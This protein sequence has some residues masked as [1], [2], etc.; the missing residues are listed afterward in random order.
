MSTLSRRTLLISAALFT[1]LA[2][3]PASAQSA[4]AVQRFT[5]AAFAA[6]QAAGKA[7]VIEVTAPWCPT[8]RTQKPIIQSLQAKPEFQDVTLMEV[9]FDSQKDVLMQLKVSA[10]STLIAFKGNA[11][12]ARSVGE[13]R[14][15]EIEKLF[16]TAI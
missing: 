15:P 4:P 12:T 5:P 7:I 11:E 6:A 10:Q 13:T 9:D 16:K 3:S 8:C 14:A 2:A 1:A